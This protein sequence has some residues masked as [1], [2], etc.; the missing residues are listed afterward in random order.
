MADSINLQ[1]EETDDPYRVIV[2]DGNI[3]MYDTS[4]G[5][6]WRKADKS[7]SKWEEVEG[8]YDD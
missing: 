3:Y 5:Q 2:Q 8:L 7:D 6:V 4:T 1:S